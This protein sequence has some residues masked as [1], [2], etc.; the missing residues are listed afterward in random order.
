MTTP[1]A[2]TLIEARE[3]KGLTPTQA[4]RDLGVRY[5]YLWRWEQGFVIPSARNLIKL[6]EY[7]RLDPIDMLAVALKIKEAP[8]NA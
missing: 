7:Y 8:I 5:S 2:K 4:A 6:A 1:L 3:A